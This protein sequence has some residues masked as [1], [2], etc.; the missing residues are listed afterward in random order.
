MK[1]L[2]TIA[3]L[4]AVMGG[5]FA[6]LHWVTRSSASDTF[7]ELGPKGPPEE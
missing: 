3:A 2:A 1:T 4:T 7:T 5:Y 6:A